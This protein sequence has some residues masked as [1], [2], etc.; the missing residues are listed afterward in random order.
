MPD[1]P[2][3]RYTPKHPTP[4]GG[5]KQK[6]PKIENKQPISKPES[7]EED[8]SYTP[9]QTIE[10][11]TPAHGVAISRTISD[12][13]ILQHVA[14]RSGETKN[15][16]IDTKKTAITTLDRINDLR[17]ETSQ[18]IDK[19]NTKVDGVIQVVGNVREEVGRQGGQNTLI[20]SMLEDLQED[21]QRTE[22]VITTTRLA[23]VEVDKSRKLTDVEIAKKRA[24]TQLDEFKADRAL[25]RELTKHLVFKIVAGIGV[26][27]AAI[28]AY[29]LAR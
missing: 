27:W 7:W 16:A 20:I 6:I 4:P 10:R 2:R 21:R 13:E 29:Y 18:R 5:A 23:E 1:D 19:L 14:R 28:S 11:K 17:D 3:D 12:S 8:D 9:V 24:D 15:V 26:V 22:H 25:R